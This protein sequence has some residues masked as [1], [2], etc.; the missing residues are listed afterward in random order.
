ML[1]NK[2]IVKTSVF[3]KFYNKLFFK[4]KWLICLIV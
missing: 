4:F 1:H 3:V 2:N